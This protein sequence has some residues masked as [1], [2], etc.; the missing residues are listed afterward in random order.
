MKIMSPVVYWETVKEVELAFKENNKSKIEK[1]T[2]YILSQLIITMLGFYQDR[3]E[4]ILFE[5]YNLPF[6]EM[7][8]TSEENRK[9]LLGWLNRLISLD[10]S[11]DDYEFGKL[12]VDFEDWF[13]QIGGR[14]VRFE[15]RDPY[16]LNPY[17]VAEKLGVSVGTLKKYSKRGFEYVQN[18]SQ[19]SIPKHMIPLWQDPVYCLKVQM[20]F[21]EN[22]IRNQKAE[23]RIKEV[24]N[25]ILEFQIKYKA[26]TSKEAFPIVDGNEM[27]IEDIQ[28]FYEWES[29]EEEYQELKEKL[30]RK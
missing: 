17:E 2:S 19:R 10:I 21:H 1:E 15:Y 6:D 30:N 13:Y 24:N 4:S 12:K 18:R 23:N 26:D 16:L 3:L 28:D 22:K 11:A 9:A 25:E 14:D 5:P 8:I 7:Y 20:V 27:D 29:L